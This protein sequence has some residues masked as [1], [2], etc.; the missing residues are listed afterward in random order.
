MQLAERARQFAQQFLARGDVVITQ[1][2]VDRY[3]RVPATMR[4]GDEDLGAA[5]IAHGLARAWL[6]RRESWC[7]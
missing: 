1:T 2:G 6:C 7:D 4:R 3:G 5:L